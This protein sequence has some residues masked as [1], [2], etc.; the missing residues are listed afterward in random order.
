MVPDRV[1]GVALGDVQK[2]AASFDKLVFVCFNAETTNIY[3]K[4]LM[5]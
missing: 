1:T 3:N 4:V 5:L 2:Y